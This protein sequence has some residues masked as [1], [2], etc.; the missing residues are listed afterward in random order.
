[1]ARAWEKDQ[2]AGV[3][4]KDGCL[5]IDDGW[6]HGRNGSDCTQ[7]T[8]SVTT[9]RLV[10]YEHSRRSDPDVKSS[11]ALEKKNSCRARSESPRAPSLFCAS[12][13]KRRP[14]HTLAPARAEAR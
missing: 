2:H 1:M 4:K 6:N 7:P 12:R 14:S 8:I 10:H 9:G 11:Q 3:T 5:A 13:R